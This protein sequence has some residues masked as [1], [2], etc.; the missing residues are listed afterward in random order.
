[1]GGSTT[2]AHDPSAPEDR[3]TSPFE[4]G[5]GAPMSLIAQTVQ[6]NSQLLPPDQLNELLRLRGEVSRLRSESRE[7]AQQQSA[8]KNTERANPANPLRA[9]LERMPDK[10]IPEVQGLDEKK[11]AEAREVFGEHLRH[12]IQPP[13][14]AWPK[15]TI[16]PYLGQECGFILPTASD[17]RSA[18]PAPSHIDRI[19]IHGALLRTTSTRGSF[20]ARS[21]ATR[22]QRAGPEAG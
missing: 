4:W 9:Q 18:S 8:R 15:W 1:M 7:L 14:K 2:A 13:P 6:T 11:W 3:G 12:W 19:V 20:R 5:G 16:T 17:D 21:G 22:A 10:Y